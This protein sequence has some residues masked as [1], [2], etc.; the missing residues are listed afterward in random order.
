MASFGLAMVQ[1]QKNAQ[2]AALGQ[3][4]TIQGMAESAAAADRAND[5]WDPIEIAARKRDKSDKERK[6]EGLAMLDDYADLIANDPFGGSKKL[7]SEMH[8]IKVDDRGDGTYVTTSPSGN[9]T[10]YGSAAELSNAAIRSV[11]ANNPDIIADTKAKSDAIIAART[12][13][14]KKDQENRSL[15][16]WITNP[17]NANK[18]NIARL[19]QWGETQRTGMTNSSAERRAW[20]DKTL[21]QKDLP[22]AIDFSLA[23]YGIFRDPTSKE[24]TVR[25]LDEDGNPARVSVQD[26]PEE[27]FQQFRDTYESVVGHVTT[28]PKLGL[29]PYSPAPRAPKATK[30]TSTAEEKAKSKGLPRN[31]QEVFGAGQS[32]KQESTWDDFVDP[33]VPAGNVQFLKNG[34]SVISINPGSK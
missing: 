31:S 15:A 19:Q 3:I 4:K 13:A 16:H 23:A 25:V 29:S 27:Q 33:Q 24:L 26:L 28:T 17:S 12:E 8:G 14:Q 1:G 5:Y 7:F 11:Y 30:Q 21:G 34:S 6:L 18:M 20:I 22:E 9:K 32:T 10:L 2:D